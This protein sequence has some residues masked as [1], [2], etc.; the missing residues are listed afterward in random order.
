MAAQIVLLALDD[1]LRLLSN[2]TVHYSGKDSSYTLEVFTLMMNPFLEPYMCS[3]CWI[4]TVVSLC[5][6]FVN[7]PC[8][9]QLQQ[10]QW[11]C[12]HLSSAKISE[13]LIKKTEAGSSLDDMHGY[14]DT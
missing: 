14:A 7:I 1:S 13:K 3:T 10:L 11:K 8:S 2:I 12:D 5:L 9:Q 6:H 4:S